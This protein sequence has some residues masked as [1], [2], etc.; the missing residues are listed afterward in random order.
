MYAYIRTYI[1]C[2]A[3]LH[4]AADMRRY[5]HQLRGHKRTHVYCKGT[6]CI[7]FIIYFIFSKIYYRTGTSLHDRYAC[8][9]VYA[10]FATQTYTHA[11]AHTKHALSRATH[12]QIHTALCTNSNSLSFIFIHFHT[13]K[14]THSPVH[15]LKHMNTLALLSLFLPLHLPPLRSGL[16]KNTNTQTHS[17]PRQSSFW[18]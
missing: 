15:T 6:C 14:F 4:Y 18:G 2:C 10:L 8:L 1:S 9:P 11:D 5:T 3:D 13:R 7:I 17:N 16:V 12:T